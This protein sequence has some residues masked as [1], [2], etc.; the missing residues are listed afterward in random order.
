MFAKAQAGQ[1][2]GKGNKGGGGVGVQVPGGASTMNI[3]NAGLGIE[4]LS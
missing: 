3:G 1:G 2:A 4:G